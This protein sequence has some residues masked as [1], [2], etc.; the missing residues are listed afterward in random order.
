MS[1]PLGRG[2]TLG[3][4]VVAAAML[5]VACGSSDQS[6]SLKPGQVSGCYRGLPTARVALHEDSAKLRGVHRVT[7]NRLLRFLPSVTVPGASL[8]VKDSATMVCTF[9]F[10]GHFRPGQ[11][12]GAAP[13]A[14]GPEAVVVV[15]SEDLHLVASYVGQGLPHRASR[16]VASARLVVESPLSRAARPAGAVSAS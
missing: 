6:L 5:L 9:T 15:S 7:V 10:E 16:R 2:M 8:P 1:T 14:Q 13:Q 3:A 12:T 11:V 4:L